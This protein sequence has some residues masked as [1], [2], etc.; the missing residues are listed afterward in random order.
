MVKHLENAYAKSDLSGTTCKIKQISSGELALEEP[1]TEDP[2]LSLYLYRIGLNEHLRNRGPAHG[3]SDARAPLSL[4][5]HY[6]LTVWAAT[7]DNEQTILGWALR[8]LH[9]LPALDASSLLP[10]GGW[11]PGDVI[12]VLPAEIS[13]EDMMRIWDAVKPTYRVSFPYIARVVRI[14][15][16]ESEVAEQPVVK[17]QLVF[18][19]QEAR[20]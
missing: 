17:T 13:T 9:T 1:V 6:L 8:Q 14:D 11:D 15:P 4:D 18:S 19:D 10:E 16:K 20:P 3:P 7:P 12:H 2:A 5:L